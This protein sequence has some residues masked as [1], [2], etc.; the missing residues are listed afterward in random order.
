MPS[1]R[2]SEVLELRVQ[3]LNVPTLVFAWSW[4]SVTFADVAR[5]LTTSVTSQ[6]A[7]VGT[8]KKRVAAGVCAVTSVLLRDSEFCS[9]LVVGRNLWTMEELMDG[10]DIDWI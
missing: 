2:Q 10:C 3:S 1:L 7:I 8:A 6:D 4:M 9:S 5:Q